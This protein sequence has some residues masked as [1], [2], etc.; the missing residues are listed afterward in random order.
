MA[1]NVLWMGGLDDGCVDVLNQCVQ[2]PGDMSTPVLDH[3]R[4]A[5]LAWEC[6]ALG[7]LVRCRMWPRVESMVE[8][9]AL[10]LDE[11]VCRMLWRIGIL[12]LTQLRLTFGSDPSWEALQLQ[13]C[14][15]TQAEYSKLMSY[16]HQGVELLPT[17]RRWI[18]R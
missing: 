6:V 13:Q 17:A 4:F 14:D 16:E 7:D 11:Q 10:R 9:L 3:L 12:F 5:R 15:L 2:L 8:R 1:E 18:Q